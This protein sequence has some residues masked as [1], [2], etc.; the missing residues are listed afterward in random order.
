[1][2][3]PDPETSDLR[4]RASAATNPAEEPPIGASVD[5]ARHDETLH[6]A[7]S[8]LRSSNYRRFATGFL[9]SSTGLQMLGAGV[10]WEIYERTKD[11]L[12]LGWIGVARALPVILFALP[13]GQIVDH[14]DRRKVLVLTQ[15]AMGA[16]A[17]LLALASALPSMPLWSLY[18]A[19]SL[20]GCARVFNGPS[21]ATLLPLIVDRD[22]FANA[23]TWNSGAFHFA[24]TIG[25]ILAGIL[26]AAFNA[27][28]PVYAITAGACWMFAMTASLLKPR[29]SDLAK[30]PISLRSMVAGA[31]HVYQE[32]TI[33]AAITLDLFAVMLGGATAL[34]P[35]FAKDIL[36]VA[37]ADYAWLPTFTRVWI[38]QEEVRYGILRA[39]PFV[40]AVLMTLV[41][42]H[43][44]PTRRAGPMLL[45]AVAGFGLCMIVFGLSTSF[46]VSLAA[47]FVSGAIDNISVVIRHVLVQVRTPDAL[48]G[49]VSAVNS[50]FIES[51]NELGGF[52][53]GLVA[54]L[55]GPVISVVSGGIG[56]VVVAAAV[57]LAW[58]QVR[59]LRDLREK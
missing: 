31:R 10:G 17:A 55:V 20:M 7:Y 4:V 41:L 56:T 25:P 39:A 34:L 51:S 30:G 33:L 3:I 43:R 36:T 38:A 45:A 16:A 12:A 42:A 23:V 57:A 48:R 8:A 59:S 28:W 2:K 24:A 18:A 40:G 52:E 47:L 46:L 21:R 54:K 29:P 53:S 19:L 32:K 49:R 11:P 58:P 15:L 27:A 50:V 6:D 5:V 13:A 37:P 35:I 14:F 1:M 9:V 44:P 26:L 22:T